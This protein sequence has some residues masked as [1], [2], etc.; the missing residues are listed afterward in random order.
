MNFE[1]DVQ[2]SLV[3]FMMLLLLF[4]MLYWITLKAPDR[5]CLSGYVF[6]VSRRDPKP[7]EPL[8]L[9]HPT[10][11]R[12]LMC[13]RPTSR[14]SVAPSMFLSSSWV[15]LTHLLT[16]TM[17]DGTGEHERRSFRDEVFSGLWTLLN[18]MFIGVKFC[19]RVPSFVQNLPTLI[20]WLSFR[21]HP[22]LYVD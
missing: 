17:Q 13:F 16:K 11:V 10:I 6:E 5:Q 22:A 15:R 4:A 18:G 7:W 8:Q 12:L 20:S 21:S 2:I 1:A 9:H 14:Y 3:V 19:P